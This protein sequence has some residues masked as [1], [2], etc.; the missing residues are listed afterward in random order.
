[1][2]D[3]VTIQLSEYEA[4]VTAD[5]LT[6]AETRYRD[7]GNDTLAERARETRQVV[8]SAKEAFGRMNVETS[9]ERAM[10]MSNDILAGAREADSDGYEST[11][12]RFQEIANQVYPA[13]E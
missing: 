3:K 13:G 9:R 10:Q 8:R 12:G 5:A 6:R 11:A 1:M 2:T 7:N 4:S